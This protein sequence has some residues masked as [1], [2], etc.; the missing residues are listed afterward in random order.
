MVPVGDLSA[1]SSDPFVATPSGDSVVGRGAC[2]MKAGVAAILAAVAAAQSGGQHVPTVRRAFRHR[3]GG[4]RARRLRHLGPR[5]PRSVPASSPSRPSLHADDRQ[6]RRADLPDRGAGPGRPRQH[7]VRRL[8]GASTPTC[9]STRAGGAGA[10]PQRDPSNRLTRLPDRLPA[11]RSAGCTPATGPAPCPDRL[12]A[13]GRYGLRIEE[14]PAIARAELEDARRRRRPPRALPPRPPAAGELAGG[15]FPGGRLP[16]GHPLARPGG[17]RSRRGHRL[18]DP[19]PSAAPPTAATS[20]STPQAGIPTLHYGPGDVRQ[21]HGPDESVPIEE[22]LT[23]AGSS[24]AWCCRP[25]SGP[26]VDQLQPPGESRVDHVVDQPL[27]RSQ[28]TKARWPR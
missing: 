1:W 26:P 21:A 27:P 2:D 9:R 8:I 24:R 19:P 18:A 5:P 4:R 11:R 17:R 20:G 28:G 7:P 12:V 3:R 23:A 13:E 25:F 6:C 10:P 16:P 15:Q 22:L 14:D